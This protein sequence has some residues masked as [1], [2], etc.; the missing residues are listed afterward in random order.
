M[1]SSISASGDG[2]TGR[3]PGVGEI[4]ERLATVGEGCRLFIEMLETFAAFSII[5]ALLFLAGAVLPWLY[6]HACRFKKSVAPKSGPGLLP[7]SAKSRTR[8]VEYVP[9]VAKLVVLFWGCARVPLD[10]GRMVWGYDV[11]T[12]LCAVGTVL[13]WGLVV[14]DESRNIKTEKDS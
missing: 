4:A 12:S 8:L 2:S 11:N 9:A 3:R 13:L 10:I 5:V 6:R 1:P 7:I 14:F